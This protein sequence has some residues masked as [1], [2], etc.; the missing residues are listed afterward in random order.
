MA[1]N[2]TNQPVYPNDSVTY[3]M[4]GYGDTGASPTKSVYIEV[5]GPAGAP[6]FPAGASTFL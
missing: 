3:V 5:G 2:K 6:T 4:T 1:P